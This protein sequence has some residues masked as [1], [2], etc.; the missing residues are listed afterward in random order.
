MSMQMNTYDNTNK[1]EA[2][3]WLDADCNSKKYFICQRGELTT[4]LSQSDAIMT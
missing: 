1:Y 4:M 2:G 3:K